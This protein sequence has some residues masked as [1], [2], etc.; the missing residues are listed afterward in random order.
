MS[1]NCYGAYG[2]MRS[3]DRNDRQLVNVGELDTSK[4]DQD[5]WV[6]GRLHTSRSKGSANALASP[7]LSVVTR[8]H[9]LC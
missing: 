6:R 5:L 8:T 4:A 2:L 3:K 1:E 7:L 9:V